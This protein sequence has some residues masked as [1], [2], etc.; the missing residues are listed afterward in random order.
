[1]QVAADGD[2]LADGGA[3]RVQV[4]QPPQHGGR[5]AQNLPGDVCVDPRRLREKTQEKLHYACETRRATNERLCVEEYANLEGE[6]VDVRQVGQDLFS[7][8]K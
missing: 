5:V 1:M 2:L 3:D 8:A 7:Y 4:G 6:K